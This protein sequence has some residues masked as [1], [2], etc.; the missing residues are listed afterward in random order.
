M[1]PSGTRVTCRAVSPVGRGYMALAGY[2]VW[3]S[4]SRGILRPRER[5]GSLSCK[6]G[7]QGP[8]KCSLQS[9]GIQFH[10]IKAD[11]IS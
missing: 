4:L 5:R 7:T 11:I 2:A 1:L 6:L 3:A 8:Q 9:K 10:G